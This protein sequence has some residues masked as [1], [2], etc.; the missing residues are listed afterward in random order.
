MLVAAKEGWPRQRD[1]RLTEQAVQRVPPAFQPLVSA[2]LDLLRPALP[3][4]AMPV[5]TQAWQQVK[6]AWAEVM[7]AWQLVPQAWGQVWV[8]QRPV[9]PQAWMELRAL[10]WAPLQEPLAPQNY[11]CRL[12]SRACRA[13]S[14]AVIRAQP[15]TS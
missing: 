8:Q 11:P 5:S 1:T 4:Q 10:V 7:K 15:A 2:P 14:C 3:R 13:R 6:P 12:R 9:W